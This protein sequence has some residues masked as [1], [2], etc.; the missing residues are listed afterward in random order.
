MKW[1][2]RYIWFVSDLILAYLMMF[3]K[4]AIWI[5]SFIAINILFVIWIYFV[6]IRE[7]NQKEQEKGD[8]KETKT[9]VET[10]ENKKG[11]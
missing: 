9:S 5:I 6:G 10:N 8:N 11:E 4:K 7:I 2:I 3:T 1:L